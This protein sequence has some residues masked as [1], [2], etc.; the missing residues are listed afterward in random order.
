MAPTGIKTEKYIVPTIIMSSQM[1]AKLRFQK[2]REELVTHR[3]E[4]LIGP[5]SR[6]GAHGSAGGSGPALVAEGG[7]WASQT[8]ALLQQGLIGRP[9]GSR[10]NPAALGLAARGQ[11]SIELTERAGSSQKETFFFTHSAANQSFSLYDPVC[12]LSVS[13]STSRC[14]PAQCKS[15]RGKFLRSIFERLWRVRN[16]RIQFLFMYDCFRCSALLCSV[17]FNL[18]LQ[19]QIQWSPKTDKSNMSRF[20]GKK[21]KINKHSSANLA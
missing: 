12:R 11:T 10:W 20:H 1:A 13:S 17:F 21:G 5:A 19:M 9:L 16:E 4:A 6:A 15:F 2:L 14:S 7:E 18:L 8:A 3:S